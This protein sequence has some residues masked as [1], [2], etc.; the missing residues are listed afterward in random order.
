[1]VI[2]SSASWRRA[3]FANPGRPV[4]RRAKSR[5]RVDWAYD[6][7][8][9]EVD[10]LPIAER[11]IESMKHAR[12]ARQATRRRTADVVSLFGL[13]E[14]SGEPDLTAPVTDPYVGD[15]RILERHLGGIERFAPWV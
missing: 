8:F 12:H 4:R 2:L 6:N 14:F 15:I 9:V 5:S 7:C 13:F 11:M 1:M 3:N 10:V